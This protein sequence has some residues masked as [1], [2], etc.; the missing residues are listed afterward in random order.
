[1]QS[2]YTDVRGFYLMLWIRSLVLGVRVY[3]LDLW[4]SNRG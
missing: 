4:M 2:W 3:I 1:M